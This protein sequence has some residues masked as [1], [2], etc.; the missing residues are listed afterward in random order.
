L[1]S[2]EAAS[3]GLRLAVLGVNYMVQTLTHELLARALAKLEQTERALQA[4]AENRWLKMSVEVAREK[5][6]S[7]QRSLNA[8][9]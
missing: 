8:T 1:V 4:D 9:H 3:Y 2:L 5:V 7:I 6:E